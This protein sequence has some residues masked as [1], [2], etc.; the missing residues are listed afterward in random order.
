MAQ[1]ELAPQV[2]EGTRN[3]FEAL[4]TAFARGLFCYEIF[5]LVNDRGLLVFEQ[6]LRDRF[7]DHHKGTVTFVDPRDGSQ[8]PVGAAKYQQMHDVLRLDPPTKRVM[9]T[10]GT[11]TR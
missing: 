3:S 4:R 10:R 6:A 1:F 11:P 7:I 8:H 5:T 2:A 9:I